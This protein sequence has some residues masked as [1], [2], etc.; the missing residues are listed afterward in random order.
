[1]AIITRFPRTEPEIIALALV[2]VQ[3]LREAASSTPRRIHTTR[4]PPQ[5]GYASYIIF[6]PT[7]VFT[8]LMSLIRPGSTW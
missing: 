5:G 6:P 4:W 3:G 1:M 2:V 8:T 7:T